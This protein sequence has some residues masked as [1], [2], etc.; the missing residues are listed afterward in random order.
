MLKKKKFLIFFKEINKFGLIFSFLETSLIKL[1]SSINT[2][3]N[4]IINNN[5]QRLPNK[6][7]T[8]PKH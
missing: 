4:I 3:V 7:K 5:R 8:N 2:S 1:Y 6:A